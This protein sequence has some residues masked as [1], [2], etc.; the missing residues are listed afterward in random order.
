MPEQRRSRTPESDS[1]PRHQTE[2]ED[3]EE[4]CRGKEAG[5]AAELL[6]VPISSEPGHE[7]VTDGVR[8]HQP[9][10]DDFRPNQC[11]AVHVF[12]RV[13]KERAS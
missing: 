13:L 4:L 6:L 10:H 7:V 11:R 3:T 5:A 2:V 12:N 8:A 1:K 9:P